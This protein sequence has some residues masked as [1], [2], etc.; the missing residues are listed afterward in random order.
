ML[1]FLR[2][3]QRFFSHDEFEHFHSAW[4]LAHG[5]TPYLDFF[6]HHHPLFWYLIVPFLWIFGESTTSLLAVRFLMGL[7]TLGMAFCVYG[8][9]KEMTHSREAGFLSALLLLSMGVFVESGIEIRPDVPYTLLGLLCI[10]FLNLFLKTGTSKTLCLAAGCASLSFL[11]SL[12]AIF[13]LASYVPL[14]LWGWVKRR[15]SKVQIKPFLVW[16]S[17]PVL[18]FLGCLFVS[19]ALSEYFFNCWVL[20]IYSSIFSS[21]FLPMNIF[22]NS[23]PFWVLSIGAVLWAWMDRSVGFE[24]KMVAIVALILLFSFVFFRFPHRHLFMFPIALLSIVAG[25]FLKVCFDVLKWGVFFRCLVILVVFMHF[26]Y[27]GLAINLSEGERALSNRSQL[28]KI[29]FVI[30]NSTPSDFIYDGDIQFNLFRPDLHYFWYSVGEN[31]NL[32]KYNKLRERYHDYNVCHLIQSKKP[33]FISAYHLDLERCPLTET[34][35]STPFRD[36][37]VLAS[38]KHIN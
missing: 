8:I 12:K 17:W 24:L 23:I 27:L 6:Q 16:F 37:Y 25:C 18:I 11:F 35:Q 9:A 30:K 28:E 15:L 10:Y 36:V 26:T 22:L 14:G 3:Q 29:D 38:R 32:A 2:S 31:K 34:Y 13:L 5:G 19:N 21:P 4:Y 20:N 1:I 33:K 7:L